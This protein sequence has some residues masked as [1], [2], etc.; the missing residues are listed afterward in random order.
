MKFGWLLLR[1][2]TLLSLVCGI[3][4]QFERCDR[5]RKLSLGQ[6]VVFKYPGTGQVGVSCRLQ[7]IAPVNSLI[8]ASC[9]FVVPQVLTKI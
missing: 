4:S 3:R 1:V 7:A 9:S 5:I 2:L 8:E 6:T